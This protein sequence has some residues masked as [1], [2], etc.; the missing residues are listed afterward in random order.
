MMKR[1]IAGLMLGALCCS[2]FST[3]VYPLR[4]D[5]NRPST[6]VYE[7]PGAISSGDDSGWGDPTMSPNPG[8]NGSGDRDTIRPIFGNW[9]LHIMGR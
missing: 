1:V 9:L 5:P 4:Y 3:P 6:T 2:L 8:D 7:H